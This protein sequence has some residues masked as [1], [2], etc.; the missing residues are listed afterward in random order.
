MKSWISLLLTLIAFSTQAQIITIDTLQNE[1]NFENVDLGDNEQDLETYIAVTNNTTDPVQLVWTRIIPEDCPSEWQTQVCDNNLCYF[2]EIGSNVDA[3]IGIDAP[4]ELDPSETFDGFVF[5]VWPRQVAGCCRMKLEFASVDAPDE[6]LETVLFD[7]SIN[8]TECDFT[9][10]TEQI[11]EA[12]LVNVFPNPTHDSFT[13][14][15][16][17]VV[18]QIDLYSNLGQKLKSFDFENGQYFNVADL[19]AGI[20]S[21][22]LKNKE[23]L[24]LNTLMLHKN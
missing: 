6:I 15:N 11:A 1:A 18:N 9:L 24:A 22:I 13:L 20:Y 19:N 16:N 23:G 4:F 17:D 3:E 5:H 8:S 21:L 10:S 14:S 12:Q 7:V 2:F